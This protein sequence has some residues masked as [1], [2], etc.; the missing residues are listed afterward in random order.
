MLASPPMSTVPLAHPGSRPGG[1]IAT[2][3]RSARA[4][5][6][7]AGALLAIMLYAAF[8]HGAISTSTDA[9]IQVAVAVVAAIAGA[10]GLWSGALSFSAPRVALAGVGLLAAFAAWSGVTVL[11]SVAP[12][13]TWIELNRA[14]TYVIVL[15]LAIALGASDPRAVSMDRR[16]VPRRGSRGHRLRPRAE[17]ASRAC[18]SPASS[19]STRPGRCHGYRSRSDTGT[20][21]R[22]SSRWAC[23]SALALAVDWT[24]RRGERVGALVA[25]ELMLLV[26]GFTLLARG[27]DRARGR[28]GRRASV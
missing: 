3:R 24:R 23:P 12:D 19:R 20:R 27:H 10:V 2:P 28:P 8:A 1:V 22:C 7:L 11:W 5:I 15:C 6:A 21:W 16:R 26:I 14:I 18:T 17:A 4:P 9:R 25:L 13:Q